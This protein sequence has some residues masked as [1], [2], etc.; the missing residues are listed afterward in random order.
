MRK[1]YGFTALELATTIAIAAVIAALVM[2]PYLNWLR[3]QRLR[4]AVINLTTD[5][6]MA[7]ARAIRENSFVVVQFAADSYK[8]FLDT[9][10]GLGGP[11]NW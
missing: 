7:K 4:G 2:P 11:P 8:I 1:D 10:D 3:A 5:L 6:E 9:G